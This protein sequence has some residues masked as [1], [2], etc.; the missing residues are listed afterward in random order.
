L[1]LL[2]NLSQSGAVAPPGPAPGTAPAAEPGELARRLAPG[3]ARRLAT[4]AVGGVRDAIDETGQ[5]LEAFTDWVRRTT[6][7]GRLPEGPKLRVN[8]PTVRAPQGLAEGAAR[9][10]TQ[11]L[12]GF[13]PL[14]RV[15]RAAGLVRGTAGAVAGAGADFLVFDPHDPRVSNLINDLAPSLRTPVTEYLAASPDDSEAE[16]RFKNVIEGLGLGLAAEGLIRGVMAIKAGRRVPRAE[17][18]QALA[19]IQS[20]AGA[21]Q[22]PPPPRPVTVAP[23]KPTVQV[24]RV[25]P[26]EARTFLEADPTA[27]QVGDRV[28]KIGWEQIGDQAALEDVINRTTHTFRDRI[29]VARRGRI[30]DPELRRLAS[31]LGVTV[32]DFLSRR[33]GQALNAE[34][35]LAFANLLGA[36]AKRL[37]GLADQVRAGDRSVQ[38]PFLDQLGL[39][40]ALQE[41]AFGV[42]AEAGRALRVWGLEAD[43]TLRHASRLRREIERIETGQAGAEFGRELT[44]ERLADLVLGVDDA[45]L[46]KMTRHATQPTWKDMAVEAWVNLGLLS[47]PVSHIANILGNFGTMVWVMPERAIAA[48]QLTGNGRAVVDGEATALLYGL[49]SGMRNAVKVAGQAL[50]DGR[51]LRAASKV[52][53]QSRYAISGATLG[54]SGPIGHGIDWAGTITR[55]PGRFL[56]VADEFFKAISTNMELHAQAMRQAV[57]EGLEGRPAWA[58]VAALTQDPDFLARIKPI[59]DAF[60]DYQTFTNALGPTGQAFLAFRASHPLARLVMPFVQ[61]LTNAFK[62]IQH[63]TPLLWRLSSQVREDLAAGGVRADLASARIQMGNMVSVAA[64]MLAAS[65]VLTGRGPKDPDLRREWLE[66]HQPYSVRLGNQWVSLSRLSEIGGLLML[67]ADFT[68]IVGELDEIDVLQLGS[69]IG[70]AASQVMLNKTAL[71]G[72]SDLLEAVDD[73][74]TKGARFTQR[75]VGTVVPAG[76]AQLARTLDPTVKEVRS[77]TDAIMNRVPGYGGRARLNLWGEQIV[78][79]GG[80][81]PDLISPL[82]TKTI[83]PH[84]PSDEMVRLGLQI[85]MPSEWVFGGRQPADPLREASPQDGVPLTEDEYAHYVRLAAG[86]GLSPTLP[87]LR[88]KLEAVIASDD[89]QRQS[90]GPT[91]G[92]AE[93]LRFWIHAY[94]ASARETLL[95]E[96]PALQQALQERLQERAETK[97]P[98]RAAPALPVAPGSVTDRSVTDLTTLLRTLGR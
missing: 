90:D 42:R 79:E 78:L 67:A 32:A 50:R 59:T 41:Q 9:G 24:T 21:V 75:L 63:R 85:G 72:V 57:S 28:L 22:A 47:N 5:A 34:H 20:E 93:I 56:M 86:H 88:D 48:R 54:V 51:P 35:T 71:T 36:S 81:G 82:Y 13:L 39:H 25:T 89:Y 92:K 3:T 98:L 27:L 61:Y 80:L 87:T 49:A 17:L 68:S 37:R 10:V 46:N 95:A 7:L 76:V 12:T 40:A 38:Q 8:L 73:P 64:V 91:G 33:A 65:G 44:A 45:A 31:D 26:E 18:Q 29:E 84:I 60:A 11:F 83:R 15:T 58:R 30:S 97:R 94:R 16:G 2:E 1:R 66:T 53:Q 14:F 52:E 77:Y 62:W 6:P 43:G 4:Q 96:S 74:F 70:L 69:A 55:S 23:P 19:P